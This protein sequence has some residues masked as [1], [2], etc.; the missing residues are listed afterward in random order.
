MSSAARSVSPYVALVPVL[1]GVFIAADD[2]T[3]IVTVL[4]QVMLDMRVAVTEL[5][6][7]SWTITGYLLGYLAAMP[8][9]G[10]V[11]DV[12]GRR[13]VFFAAM[14]VFMAGSVAVAVVPDLE[15]MLP[16]EVPPGASSRT[17]RS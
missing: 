17:S 10:R 16:F 5:D 1:V 11:S 14:A 7:A 4:P 12:W 13:H 9:I 15:A 6:K 8:L 3:V 2:Q